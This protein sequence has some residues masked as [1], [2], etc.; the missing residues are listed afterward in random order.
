MPN[1]VY[2]P[3]WLPCP[4]PHGPVP[5]LAFTL[6]RRSPSY[7]G[8]LR[9]SSTARS[10]PTPGPLRHH[11]DYARQTHEACASMASMTARWQGLLAQPRALKALLPI[12]AP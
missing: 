2:D 6:S 3:R 12:L 5:A 10:S 1:G 8:E 9:R 11:A 7:T 4:T